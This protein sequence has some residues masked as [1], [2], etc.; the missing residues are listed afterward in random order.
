MANA[1]AASAITTLFFVCIAS[2]T[3][4]QS[5][6]ECLEGKRERCIP[7]CV[8][9]LGYSQSECAT[10]IC[11]PTAPVNRARWIPECRADLQSRPRQEPQMTMEECLEGK[12]QR[13]VPA[14][15]NSFSYSASQCATTLCSPTAPVNRTRWIPECRAEI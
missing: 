8:N 13:C 5:M 7:T 15:V 2:A 1:A 4:A 10:S 3:W 12:Q 11:S 6:Q 9:S 14:C